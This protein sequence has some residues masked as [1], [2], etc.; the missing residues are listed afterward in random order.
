[1]S[2][3]LPVNF[4][5][6]RSDWQTTRRIAS[7]FNL[8][9]VYTTLWLLLKLI[10]FLNDH[11]YLIKSASVNP[12]FTFRVF[13]NIGIGFIRGSVY[14]L[15]LG[16]FAIDYFD[17]LVYFILWIYPV[18]RVEHWRIVYKQLHWILKFKYE[19]IFF[20]VRLVL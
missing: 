7:A 14:F 10:F 20:R 17:G 3:S 11:V 8:S 15:N 4:P 1:M 19:D 18:L 9:S 13:L 2:E 6:R 5:D 16:S 12:C